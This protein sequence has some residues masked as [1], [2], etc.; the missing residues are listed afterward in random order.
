MDQGYSGARLG[1]WLRMANRLKQF[2][3][4]EGR[5]PARTRLGQV[6]PREEAVLFYWMRSQRRRETQLSAAQFDELNAIP[7]FSW[8]PRN[9][10]WFGALAI[11]SAWIESHGGRMP[12]RRGGDPQERSV[13]TW[14]ERQ[15]RAALKG[16]LPYDRVSALKAHGFDG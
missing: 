12:R 1:K 13:A 10:S 14:L 3:D 16:T 6:S 8:D 15:R 5:L 4:R 9:D 2:V 11:A 7:T